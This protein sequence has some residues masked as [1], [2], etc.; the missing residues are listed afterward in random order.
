MKIV[1]KIVSITP[2]PC[3]IIIENLEKLLEMARKGEISSLVCVGLTQNGDRISAIAVDNGSIYELVGLVHSIS[4]E[5][6]GLN[7]E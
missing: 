6:L 7:E 3:P 1:P 2:E 4:I 5:L